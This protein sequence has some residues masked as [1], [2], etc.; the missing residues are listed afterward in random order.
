MKSATQTRHRAFDPEHEDDA[1]AGTREAAGGE[2]RAAALWRAAEDERAARRYHDALFH[3]E[4]AAPLFDAGNDH[5]RAGAFRAAYADLLAFLGEA[6]ERD[7]YLER[8]PAEYAAAARHFERAGLAHEQAAVEHG[9]A[10]L[11]LLLGQ[12]TGAHERLDRALSFLRGADEAA[13]ARVEETRARVL[14]AEGRDEEAAEL[15]RAAVRALEPSGESALLASALT[16]HGVALARLAR[17]EEALDALRRAALV[18]GRAGD[19]EAE[20]HAALALA[21]ELIGHLPLHE[22]AE[23]FE[24]ATSRLTPARSRPLHARL[25]ACAR[26]LVARARV[27][28]EPRDWDGFSFREAVHRFEASVIGRAL[29]DAGG[30]V[31]RAAHLLG[32]RHHNSLASI[33]NNRHREL[34]DARSPIKP[35][36]RSIITVRRRVQAP[37]FADAGTGRVATV[38][39]VEDDPAVAGGVRLALED[40]GWRVETC[41]DGDDALSRLRRATPYD[42]LLLDYELPGADGLE[43]ARA[44]RSLPHRSATPILMFCATDCEREAL[45]AGADAFLRKP[46]DVSALAATARR[47]LL[48]KSSRQ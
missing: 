39:H 23:S 33:L 9:V 47:L 37:R 44:A 46:Q 41:A 24:R 20:G 35:R 31:S 42:L 36:R 7:D 27:E 38:L 3:Y 45:A 21:E 43:I 5:A 6:D 26:R 15:S 10:R 1:R 13:R 19:A 48:K 34:L 2:A 12:T 30:S 25:C 28:Q 29:A 22:L 4:E 32:F 11:L 14:L 8:A 40:E 16:A 18:A 17:P